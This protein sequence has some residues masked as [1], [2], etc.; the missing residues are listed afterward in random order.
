MKAESYWLILLLIVTLSLAIRL[1]SDRRHKWPFW[2][3]NIKQIAIISVDKDKEDLIQL[4][5]LKQSNGTNAFNGVIQSSIENFDENQDGRQDGTC[6]CAST[7]FVCSPTISIDGFSSVDASV[8]VIVS[9]C[10][11]SSTCSTVCTSISTSCSSSC[12]ISTTL[13]ATY[14]TS[15]LYCSGAIY[16]NSIIPTSY[17]TSAGSSTSSSTTVYSSGCQSLSTACS[18]TTI[19][20][21]ARAAFAAAA[22]AVAIAVGVGAGV[23]VAQGAEV[24]Q[25]IA[26]DTEQ[27][28]LE[29]VND[30]LLTGAEDNSTLNENAT[31]NAFVPITALTPSNLLPIPVTGVSGPN[32]RNGDGCGDE[33]ILFD[34]GNCYPLLRRG[35]CPDRSQWLT[36]DP[37]TLRVNSIKRSQ[38]NVFLIHQF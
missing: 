21:L 23:R 18:T 3:K 35:P 7:S 10:S 15:Y 8:T 5:R 22:A 38:S 11:A 13:T 19:N 32:F 1:K 36:V 26:L 16:G 28:V 37:F 29:L 20:R 4:N 12:T 9:S 31:I 33:S 27:Q 17:T 2:K 34:D 25:I 14:Y 6:T 24:Q 30:F